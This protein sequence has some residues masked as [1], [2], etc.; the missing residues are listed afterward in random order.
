MS[1]RTIPKHLTASTRKWVKSVID[2]Y[3]LQDHQFHILLL[4]AG[5]LDR[6]EQARQELDTHGMVYTDKAGQPKP[7]PEVIIERDSKDL[8]RR[9][10]RELNLSEESTEPRPPSLGYGGK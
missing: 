10:L 2:D 5:A 4:A 1:K 3:E 7:R 8:F 6:A 9:L